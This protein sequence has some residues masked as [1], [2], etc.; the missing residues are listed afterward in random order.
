MLFE[1]PAS[2]PSDRS[3]I[4]S[5]PPDPST[6]PKPSVTPNHVL[7]LSFEKNAGLRLFCHS[8]PFRQESGV[9]SDTSCHSAGSLV[10]GSRFS[11]LATRLKIASVCPAD[12]PECPLPQNARIK[13]MTEL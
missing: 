3:L 9:N 5:E 13:S 2:E 1:V 7:P 11:Q 6:L 10:S 12:P 8:A 4:S